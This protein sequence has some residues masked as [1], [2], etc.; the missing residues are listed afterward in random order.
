MNTLFYSFEE[1]PWEQYLRA[2]HSDT[3]LSTV[4]FLTM[5]ETEPEEMLEEAFEDLCDRHISLDISELPMDVGNGETAVRLRWEQQLTEKENFLPELDENDPLRLYLEELAGIPAF[6]DPA[7]MAM[8]LLEEPSDAL[9]TALVNFSLSRVAELA[10]QCTGHGVLLL[11]LV[12]EGNLGLWQ[13]VMQYDGGDFEEERDWYIRQYLAKAV[14]LQARESGI[15]RKMRQAMEDYRSV[16]E[17]LLMELG[18]NPTLEEI[19]EAMHVTPEEATV[20]EEMLETARLLNRVKTETEVPEET[21]ESEQA[22]EDTAYFQMRQRINELLSELSEQDAKLL[23]LRFGLEG[24]LPMNPQQ[25]A[26]ALGMTPEEV[27]R[28]EAAALQHLRKNG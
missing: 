1:T 5:L 10:K 16:D 20:A 23:T 17:R 26:R 8:Q 12:Q 27:T 24:G 3:Q 19:A 21:A 28:R 2:A 7:A 25:A 14:T 11:D 6:G 22:V 15:G 9:R 18:R 4:K 13:A